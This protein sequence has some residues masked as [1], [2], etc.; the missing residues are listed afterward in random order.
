[1]TDGA[2]EHDQVRVWTGP[3]RHGRVGRRAL[4]VWALLVGVVSLGGSLQQAQAATPDQRAAALVARMTPD[5]KLDLVSSGAAGIPRLGIPP[6]RFIDG[7]NG[8]GHGDAG[9]TAFPNAVNIGAS[10][11]PSLARRYG[12]ALGRE[13][14]AKGHSL[15]AAPTLNIVRTPK[16]GRAAETLGEDPFLTSSL[17]APE[18]RGIQ[19]ARVMAEA[20]HYAGNNQEIGRLGIPLAAPAVDDRVSSRALQEIYLP[21]FKAAADKGES[22]SVMCSYNRINGTPSCQNP[23]TLDTLKDSGLRGFVEPDAALAIRDVVAA[24]NAGVDNFQLGSLLGAAGGGTGGTAERAVLKAAVA[25]GTVSQARIDDAARR[26]LIGMIQAGVLDAPTPVSKPVASTPANRALATDISAQASVLLQNRRHVLPLGGNDRSIAVIGY[27]AGKG[28]QIEE[29]GSPAV[30]P[31]REVI[32]P[33]AGIR[34]RAPNRTKVTYALGTRGVVPLPVVPAGVLTPE[35][36]SGQGLSGTYYASAVPTFTGSPV[37]KRVDRTIDFKSAPNPLTPIPGTT[38]S[39][40]ALDRHAHS[41]QDGRVPLLADVFRRGEVVRR[42]QAD[43]ERRHRGAER[44]TGLP[45][46]T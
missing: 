16:W 41:A 8:V 2:R 43:H 24:A 19:S 18:V 38:A 17:V 46:S 40:S 36:G 5:E 27:D 21:G 20:K 12:A 23:S 25:A 11:D 28:T 4:I 22:A 35:S 13:T 44:R 31:G 42:R 32:T 1:M 26:I 29:G 30:L 14:R 33:L 34:K 10:W 3:R 7:P 15:I 6:I 9:V 45:G 37:L 39:S